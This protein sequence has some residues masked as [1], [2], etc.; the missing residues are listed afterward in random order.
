M[1]LANTIEVLKYVFGGASVRRGGFCEPIL[2]ELVRIRSSSENPY[3]PTPEH[4]WDEVHNFI[5]THEDATFYSDRPGKN[6][7]FFM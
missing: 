4:M 6:N 1:P 2:Y 3:M 5:N 7:L